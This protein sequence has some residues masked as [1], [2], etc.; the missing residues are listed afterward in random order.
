MCYYQIVKIVLWPSIGK[1][2]DWDSRTE[3]VVLSESNVI[4]A[5]SEDDVGRLTGITTNQLRYWDRTDFFRP[6]LADENR[7]WPNSRVNSFRDVVCL[8]ILNALRNEARVPL[9][10][11]REVREKLLHLGEN[12]CAKTTLYVLNRRVVFFNPDTSR[13]EDVIT[14][15]GVLQIPLIVVTGDMKKAVSSLRARDAKTIGRIRQ[16]RGVA[17]SEPVVAGT[18]ITV[19]AIK[20]F[21][22][23]GYSIDSI[24]EEYPSLT[25]EDIRAALAY[26]EAA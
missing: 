10:R 26:G 23:A 22:E 15:Q 8:K 13:K 9:P 20:A 16:S 21:H 17:S 2:Y 25:K 5:F 12:M 14:G 18:R 24:R 4:A 11:L 3:V 7:R 6:S 19:R 1:G